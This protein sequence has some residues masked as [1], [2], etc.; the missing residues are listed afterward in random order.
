MA[1]NCSVP[2]TPAVQQSSNHC[3]P[4][5]AQMLLSSF[6]KPLPSQTTLFPCINEA[7]QTDQGQFFMGSPD[8]VA[9]VVNQFANPP[10]TR[11]ANVRTRDAAPSCTRIVHALSE[12]CTP[13]AVVVFGG[14]H[15]VVVNGASGSGYPCREGYALDELS[16]YNSDDG[17]FGGV[18]GVM[19]AAEAYAAE[20][21]TY[22]AFLDLYFLA[23]GADDSPIRPYTDHHNFAIVT[24]RRTAAIPAPMPAPP[25]LLCYVPETL[26]CQSTIDELRADYDPDFDGAQQSALT[27]QSG[28]RHYSLVPFVN[29]KTALTSLLCVDMATSYMGGMFGFPG[30]VTSPEMAVALAQ[31]HQLRKP[32]VHERSDWREIQHPLRLVWRPCMESSSPF[33][34]FYVV[35]REQNGERLYVSLLGGVVSER[36]HHRVTGVPLDLDM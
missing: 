12:L 24:D 8:G 30:T 25:A 9:A 26:P 11:F 16:F 22:T 36:L 3:A 29:S 13:A 18:P 4:A 10:T 27:V 31:A 7:P 14:T 6:S 35:T 33:N 28:S 2:V 20:R 32:L 1:W 17:C 34:P 23:V 19:P 21:M 15:W 5:A